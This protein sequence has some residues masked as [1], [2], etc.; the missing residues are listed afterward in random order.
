MTLSGFSV[1][2][3]SVG[4]LLFRFMPPYFSVLERNGKR[5]MQKTKEFRGFFQEKQTPALSAF[6]DAIP[7]ACHVLHG[8]LGSSYQ[9][10]SIRL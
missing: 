10:M 1:L 5:K 6:F 4:F 2:P 8:Y 7:S 3:S 9:T